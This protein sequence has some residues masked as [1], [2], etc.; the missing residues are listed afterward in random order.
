MSC[1]EVGK[2]LPERIFLPAL[3]FALKAK[4]PPNNTGK[5]HKL[6]TKLTEQDLGNQYWAVS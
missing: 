4:H 3:V 2:M 5:K 1:Q 6:G